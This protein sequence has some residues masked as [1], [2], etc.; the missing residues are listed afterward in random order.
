MIEVLC[1]PFHPTLQEFIDGLRTECLICSPYVTMG[2]AVTLVTAAERKRIQNS[3]SVKLITDI[4]APNIVNG[5]TDISALLLI[6]E[7]IQKTEIVYL[8]R[9]HAKVYISGD[10][11]AIIG[12]ANFTDGGMTRNLEYGVS[13]REPPIVR[14]IAVDLERYSQLGGLVTRPRLVELLARVNKLQEA[15]REEKNAINRKL[16][17]LTDVLQRDAEDELVRVRI[18]GRSINAI[19]A[20]TILYLLAHRPMT[21]VE[22]HSRIHDMHPDLC[23]DTVDRVIDGQRFGKLWK[24]SVRNAQQHLKRTS[25]VSFDSRTHTWAV[26]R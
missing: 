11:L 1:S 4:S 13:V 24:H 19:F 6:A 23:D 16:R 26:A 15:I 8:P 22:L 14:K 17:S 9:I 18:Q 25:R 3:L 10:S 21:T 2:P 5:S 20:E 7:R 12:S